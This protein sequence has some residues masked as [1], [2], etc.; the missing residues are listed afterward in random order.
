MANKV[1]KTR[2][3]VRVSKKKAKVKKVQPKMNKPAVSFP[4]N[5]LQPLV[6][7]LKKE[8]KRLGVAKKDLEAQDP[9]KDENRVDDNAGDADVA[10]QIAHE[11][12]SAGRMEIMKALVEIRKTMTRIKLGRYGT[13]TDCGKMIDT[14]RLAI[15]PTAELC[16]KCER[17]QEKNKKKRV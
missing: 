11:R 4:A 1:K 3:K 10:E 12:I 14:D 5:V 17:N 2:F 15:N 7:Y 8:E 6:N 13:C 9:F 16:I